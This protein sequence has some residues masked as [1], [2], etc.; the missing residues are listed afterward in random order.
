M[1]HDYDTIT[2]PLGLFHIVRRVDHG[3]TARF[4]RFE[5]VEY[6]IAALRIDTDSRLIEQQNIRVMHQCAGDVQTPLH[7]ARESG[8]LVAGA[9]GEANEFECRQRAFSQFIAL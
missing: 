6:G 8:R 3:L 9:F 5:I 7:A 1:I 2:Q 4:E